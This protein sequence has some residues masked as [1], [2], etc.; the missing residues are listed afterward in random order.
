MLTLRASH[1]LSYKIRIKN[2]PAITVLDTGSG[3][4]LV[5]RRYVHR[6]CLRTERFTNPL[7]LLVSGQTVLRETCTRT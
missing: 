1:T 3:I 4:C 5:S 2:E 7:I 6:Y